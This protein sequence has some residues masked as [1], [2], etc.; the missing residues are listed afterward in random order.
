M[1]STPKSISEIDDL[2]IIYS[3]ILDGYSYDSNLNLYIKHFAEKDSSLILRKREYL[4]HFYI[5]EGV[6]HE[7]ELLKSAIENGEW[8]AEKEERI[9]ELKYHVSD[10]EKNI[11]NIIPEQRAGIEKIIE[12]TK[13]NLADMLFDRKQILGRSVEDLVDD[14]VNDYVLFLSYYKNPECT[15][16]LEKDYDTFQ[17]WESPQLN[18]LNARLG[19]HYKRFSEEKVK[20]IACLPLFLNKF[21]YSKEDVSTFLGKPVIELT[22]NQNY[23]FFF[24]IRNLNILANSKNGPPDLQLDAKVSDVI[25]WYDLQHS[26]NLGKK[27]AQDKV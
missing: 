17:T 15:Q 5:S 13:V 24:G 8:S 7:S 19:Y 21:E 26:I 25:K 16:H 18:E 27:N 22:H 9:L 12:E 3:E 10:N 2:K 14:D 6:P 20:G 1:P 23:L 11:H 4:F